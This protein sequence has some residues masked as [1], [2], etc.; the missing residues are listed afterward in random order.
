MRFT[1]RGIHLLAALLVVAPWPLVTSSGGRRATSCWSR[2]RRALARGFPWRRRDLPEQE[3]RRSHRRRCPPPRFLAAHPEARREAVMPFLWTMIARQG[4]VYRK[5]RQGEPGQGGQRHELLLSRL[6]RDVHRLGRPAD[7]QQR[8]APQPQRQRPRMAHTAS[9]RSGARSPRSARGT[10]TRS[11]STSSGADYTVNAGWMPLGGLFAD[12]KSS[13]L[14]NKLMA[15]PSATG[16]TAATMSFTF[17]VRA[18]APPP[19][20]AAGLLRR[21]R[22]H[23]R[24]RPRRADTTSTS[25]QLHDA[26]ADLEVALGRAPVAPPV[27]RHDDP[28]RDHRP[29][30]GRP[31]A[32]LAEPRRRYAPAPKRSGSP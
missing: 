11:S 24:V 12:A 30:P 9:R 4:Q 18:G 5:S 31:A 21:A 6:Q 29:R 22:R 13:P 10:C 25:G 1:W 2:R 28:D 17:Q 23:R 27:P 20:Q 32:G 7:R 16:T 14:L 8:E 19:R 15:V 3:R 26:D